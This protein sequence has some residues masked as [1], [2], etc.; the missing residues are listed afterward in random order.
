MVEAVLGGALELAALPLTANPRHRAA[1]EGALQHIEAALAAA[2][3]AFTG[4][5]LAIDVHEALEILGEITGET[6]SEE[7]LDLIFGQFCVGK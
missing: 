1:F 2:D 4:D 3:Q 6:A 7:L 5:L